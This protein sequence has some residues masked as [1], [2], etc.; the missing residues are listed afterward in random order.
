[1]TDTVVQGERNLS[2]LY[3]VDVAVVGAG[4]AGMAAAC[5]AAE[6]GADTLLI[7]VEGYFGGTSTGGGLAT[8]CG[9]FSC[10][11]PDREVQK[12]V[13]GF[14]DRVLAGLEDR[15]ALEGP[16]PLRGKTQI[17]VYDPEVLKLVYDDLVADAGAT[18][19]LRSRV[20]DV[21]TEPGP[22]GRAS[23]TALVVETV[24]GSR[25]VR[26]GHVIDASGD[27]VVAYAAG[28]AV[29]HD[30]GEL[31]SSTT[32]FFAGGVDE[33]AAK[34]FRMAD[35]RERMADAVSAGDYD[36]PKTDGIF[37]VLSGKSKAWI[38]FTDV[39]VDAVDPDELT[40]GEVEG[41]RQA[42]AYMEFFR[43]ELDGFEDAFIDYL[44]P[45]LGVRET[46]RVVGDYVLDYDD[47]LEEARFSDAI[48]HCGWA[49]ENHDPET[50]ASDW[51]WMPD[52]GFYDI[53]YRS[54]LV[55]DLEN[56]LVAGRCA[57][58][59]H[60]VQAS[61]RVIA[62]AFAMGEA[63]GLAASLA[64]D[65]GRSLRDLDVESIQHGLRDRGAF[66]RPGLPDD[67]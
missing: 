58:A 44:A 25:A 17:Y 5:T 39:P 33:A 13:G 56:T 32:I 3:D 9:F 66:L 51:V 67:D 7:D 64:N 53:P 1:M 6:H 48:A 40:A 36:L 34:D 22:D 24:A 19:L 35:V 47:F 4:A 60:E 43:N 23:V 10:S 2:V 41:R 54:L 14:G 18:A 46:R 27:G 52:G 15:G 37:L 61:M 28:A 8:F 62:T 12:I 31:Q 45:R 42:E 59:S 49:H 20:S 30:P 21:L 29:D 50:R 16:I 11:G 38:N 26:A 57:S 65:Q 63:A 55:R